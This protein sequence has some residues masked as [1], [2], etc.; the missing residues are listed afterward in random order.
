M[1]MTVKVTGMDELKKEMKAV[2]EE[3][4]KACGDGTE[5]C[6]D[7]LA[8]IVRRNAP[9]GPTGN[10]QKAV[11][12]KKLPD[13]PYYPAVTMVGLDY[14]IAPHQHLV[15]FGT[16]PREHASGKSVGAARPNPFFRQSIDEAHFVTD[17]M[18]SHCKKPI[19][20]RGG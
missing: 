12:T 16:G 7:R 2:M 10:L 3:M 11:T 18:R 20:K 8:S 13:K 14:G 17:M 1:N 15:E 4:K 6:A 5:A 19:E 9:R